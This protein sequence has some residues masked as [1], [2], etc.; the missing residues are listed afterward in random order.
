MTKDWLSTASSAILRGLPV[1]MTGWIF[2]F[3][4]CFF[5]LKKHFLYFFFFFLNT[6][7]YLISIDH[8]PRWVALGSHCG[9]NNE[10][11]SDACGWS[12]CFFSFLIV[13]RAL[14]GES[15]KNIY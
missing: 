5:F 9:K 3:A 11:L 2:I 13:V 14:I 7:L 4:L 6:F 8:R 15:N 1:V 12:R 10:A